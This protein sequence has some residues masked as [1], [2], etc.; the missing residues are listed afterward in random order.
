MRRGE[1]SSGAEEQALTFG[2]ANDAALGFSFTIVVPEAVSMKGEVRL[3]RVP[4][5]I[6]LGVDIVPG[7]SIVPFPYPVFCCVCGAE[8]AVCFE[9]LLHGIVLRLAVNA[10]D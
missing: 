4:E 1:A 8:I 10:R 7:R 9:Q 2:S 3:S 6:V 5:P